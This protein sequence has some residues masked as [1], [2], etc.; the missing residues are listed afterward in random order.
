[1]Y[2]YKCYYSRS[3]MLNMDRNKIHM[4]LLNVL[5]SQ[6]NW[7]IILSSTLSVPLVKKFKREINNKLSSESKPR[8]YMDVILKW[9]N[10]LLFYVFWIM[11]VFCIYINCLFDSLLVMVLWIQCTLHVKE[12][13]KLSSWP[14]ESL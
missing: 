10:H 11:P 12:T 4:C 6:L 13:T 2:V 14:Q 8:E 9:Y 3:W 7:S 5:Y 1:M